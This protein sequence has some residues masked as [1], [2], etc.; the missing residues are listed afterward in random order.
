MTAERSWRGRVFIATSLDGFIAR[1]DGD[2][3][4][5]TQPRADIDH[6]KAPDQ[7]PPNGDYDTF[8]SGIDHIVMGRTTYEKVLTFGF[9]PYENYT[10]L[11]LSTHLPPAHDER[12]TVV[13]SIDAAHRILEDHQAHGVYIDGGKVIQ[14]FLAAGL[15]DEITLTHAPILLGSGLPL[16]GALPTDTHLRLDAVSHSGN[17]LTHSTYTIIPS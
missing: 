15:I 4:W 14:S 17:G 13:S 2:I 5:L 11:I 16:F 7:P 8:M 1:P 6:L 10:V 9:W 3:E 12:V